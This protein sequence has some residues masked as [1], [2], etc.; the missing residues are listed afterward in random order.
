MPQFVRPWRCESLRLC[1][2][3]RWWRSE[4]S[5]AERWRVLERL[6]ADAFLE[7][8]RRRERSLDEDRNEWKL[9]DL[10]VDRERLLHNTQ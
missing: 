1:E 9:A 3:L 5:E 8:E 6:C 4:E 2:R 10:T 7:R